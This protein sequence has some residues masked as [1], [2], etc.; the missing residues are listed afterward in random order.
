M[1]ELT[2]TD[3]NN[4]SADFGGL[5]SL[6]SFYIRRVNIAVSRDLDSKLSGLDVAKGTGKI[7]TLLIVSRHPG[8]RPSDIADIIVR[9]RSSMGRLLEKM[10]SQGLIIR[11]VSPVDQRSQELYLTAKGHHLASKVI[12]IARKQDED[13]FHM[14]T[15]YEKNIII[16]ACHKILKFH[17]SPGL[18]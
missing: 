11:R 5:E 4:P 16:H 12:R 17:Q 14:V 15:E 1:D 10:E 9:D 2:T 8:S 6:L 18:F 3:F 7:G 13:F